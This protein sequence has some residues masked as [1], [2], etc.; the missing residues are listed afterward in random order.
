M[1][2]DRSLAWLS[3][4]KHVADTDRCRDPQQNSGWSSGSLKEE[5]GEGLRGPEGDRKSIGRPTMS[6]NL[7]P[8][9]SQRPNHQPKSIQELDLS[10]PIHK[11]ICSRWAA[12]SS[13]G[14]PNDWSEG[15]L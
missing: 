4:E 2:A 12:Q 8:W 15:C 1:L 5:M 11:H 3:S 7:D 9:C 13:C 10:P 6:T 14:S